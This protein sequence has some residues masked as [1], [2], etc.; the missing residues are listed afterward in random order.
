MGSKSSVWGF[1][2]AS[3]QGC[4]VGVASF[5]PIPEDHEGNCPHR[6][7]WVELWDVTD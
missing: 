5:N 1:C 2:K 3:N 4:F 7:L 6:G